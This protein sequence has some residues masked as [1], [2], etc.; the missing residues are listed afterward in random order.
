MTKT[1]TI[2]QATT[3]A[4]AVIAYRA[5]VTHSFRVRSTEHKVDEAIKDYGYT[6][7]LAFVD[8]DDERTI[9]NLAKWIRRNAK[10]IAA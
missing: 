2:K 7:G 3:A 5:S 9:G 6:T 8:A 1:I 10:T 4:R